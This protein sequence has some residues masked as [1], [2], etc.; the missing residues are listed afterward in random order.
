MRVMSAG[1]G[2]RYLLQSVVAAD[3][4]RPLS[5]PLVEYYAVAGTPPGRWLGS[6]LASL[7]GGTLTAGDVVGEEQ[8]AL[9]LGEGRD[10][11]TGAALG[12]AFPAYRSR[13]E[14]IADRVA[15]LDG[16]LS[17]E[18]RTAATARIE[19][20]E[21]GPTRRAVAGFDV[22]FS[23]PKSVSV[24]WALANP[25]TRQAILDA[26][27][28]AIGDVIGLMERQVAAT[29]IGAS[30]PD[31]AV[32]QVE[33]DGL[34]AA[35]FDHWD[36]R[37][38]DPQLHTH[39][40]IANKVRT[41]RD[42]RWRSLDGRPLHA[43]MVALSEHY[44]AVL[45]DRLTA[46]LGVQWAPVQRG[47]DRNPSWEIAGIGLP[48]LQ[49]FSTRAGAIE[50]ETDRLI[51]AFT[52]E[53]GHRPSAATVVRLRQQAALAT[54]PDKQLHPLAEL[55]ARWQATA[56]T[57]MGSPV[58][59]WARRLLKRQPTAVSHADAVPEHVIDRLGQQ[60]VDVVGQ[61]RATW[62]HWNLH[63]EAARQTMGLRFATP[64]D[65]QAV[66]DRVIA[67]ARVRSVQLTPPELAS[68]SP[69]LLRAD[70]TSMLRPAHHTVYSSPVLLAA[71]DRLLHLGRSTIGPTV[72]APAQIPAGVRVGADQWTAVTTVA[73]SGR[74]VDVLVGPA[75][76]GKTTAM[77]TLREVWTDTHG[78]SSVV[79][80]APS[81]AAA[82]VLTADLGI[83]SDTTAKWLSDAASGRVTLQPG[84]LVI[85][86][87][88]SLAD[89]RTLAT[90]GE[91]AAT[92]GAKVLLVGDWAQLAA[93]DAGGAFALLARDRPDV[94]QLLDV[95]RF[96]QPWEATASLQLRA[97][98]A[99]VIDTYTT[100]G[101]LREG[102]SEAMLEAA[103]RAWRADQDA[104]LE[105]LLIAPTR[106]LVTAL[107]DRARND[108]ITAGHVNPEGG[109]VELRDG[110]RASAG[111]LITTRRND[112]H[113]RTGDHWVRNG[114]RWSV[115]ATHPDGSLTVHP[116]TGPRGGGL[117][118]PA[119]YVA[120][121]VDLGYAV[122]AHGA[123]GA[124]VDR[125]HLLITPA[126]T[127]ETLYVGMTR[128]R[129]ANTA[130]ITTD[131]PDLEA[132][133]TIHGS[134]DG[135]SVLRGVLARAGA[136]VS[137]HEQIRA[138]Q[139]RWT[140]I[141]QLAAEYET[142]AADA[143]R[144][145]W[146][147]LLHTSGLPPAMADAAIS[148]EAFGPLCAALRTA[149]ADH[150]D[151]D[152]ILPRIV[153]VRPFDD[154]EDIAA[155]LHHRLLRATT[156][157]TGSS[158][159]LPAPRLIAGLIPEAT[160]PMT[161]TMRQALQDRADL[162]QQ[163]AAALADT[164][165][166]EQPPWL[167][168]LGQP[169]ADPEIYAVWLYHLE[170]VVVYRDRHHISD[171]DHPLGRQHPADT[172]DRP[173][174]TAALTAAPLLTTPLTPHIELAPTVPRREPPGLTR[175][176]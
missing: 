26:H 144:P 22:T 146:T 84:Q 3:G 70:A 124:T 64:T 52:A 153:A 159:P 60:V 127:R 99:S 90:I 119:A 37:A 154:A 139:D 66:L 94:A 29:R 92:S 27:H 125:A 105:S 53:R 35:A 85:V 142:L 102:D 11:L 150:H 136:E 160:G 137:A 58:H 174:A 25:A 75:G 79:G 133:Q 21:A 72:P 67:A 46:Q 69:Q 111:D 130:Y 71:E 44:N 47:A 13:Q 131:T 143:Q 113:L 141:A 97:G 17:A 31:G 157:R 73:T 6:G 51:A 86:D 115:T 45:A 81:A 163:R 63:A 82:A 12:R 168:Q 54:R 145:R 167:G 108:R 151:V 123:Q 169:P 2:Y 65:R 156:R 61:R 41:T 59:G 24:L 34:I 107:N 7:G 129:E 138:E 78:H 112:R 158:R 135:R 128:G 118:L 32:A 103:Y 114:D 50:A 172:L 95:R 38:G 87:E 83:A 5:T 116:T 176:F 122:T 19:A 162:I 132:H 91:Q 56:A 74:V 101:R 14:R 9:L 89:T 18:E 126:M 88:A 117:V 120:E 164:A 30:G 173:A 68:T 134:P 28:A 23:A 166:A 57:V 16:S 4:N 96:Q 106:D 152:R 42:G 98:E 148:S 140:G 149:E 147:A 15:A 49:A 171:P 121:H 77:R 40:V 55:T 175:S 76:A 155:V 100:H 165:L 110:T 10:P 161:D 170:T 20:E 8:L 1:H 93:V 48:L 104:G 33:V 43:A 62:R 80:L 36:S 109:E 39:L